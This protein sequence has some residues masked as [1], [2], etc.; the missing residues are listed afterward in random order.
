MAATGTLVITARKPA[1][2]VL[3]LI[4][5][6]ANPV[7]SVDGGP[8][9]ELPWDV[10]VRLELPVGEHDLVVNPNGP[11]PVDTCC[12]VDED[13]VALEFVTAGYDSLLG[14]RFNYLD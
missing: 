5:K 9:V 6:T 11:E 8:E 12:W 3:Q 7:V 2:N 13:G 1:W 4:H 14:D 10:P